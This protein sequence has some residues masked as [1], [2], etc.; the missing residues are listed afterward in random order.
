MG[1]HIFSKNGPTFKENIQSNYL[2]KSET[3]IVPAHKNMIMVTV[4]WN[5]S[6]GKQRKEANIDLN[7]ED[8]ESGIFK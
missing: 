7:N 1:Q 8:N 5:F 2:T 4:A 6:S 3:T